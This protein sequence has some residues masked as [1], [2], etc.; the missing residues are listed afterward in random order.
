M[1]VVSSVM[2]FD[3]SVCMSIL[4]SSRDCFI[5]ALA[6]ILS[7][8]ETIISPSHVP[9]RSGKIFFFEFTN[10]S[11]YQACCCVCGQEQEKASSGP[12]RNAKYLYNWQVSMPILSRHLIGKDANKGC[13]NGNDF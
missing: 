3:V 4:T 13:D 5:S 6:G 8:S 11:P 12:R 2:D 7:V 10:Q 1:G 9:L